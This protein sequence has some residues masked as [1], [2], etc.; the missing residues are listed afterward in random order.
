MSNPVLNDKNIYP[1]NK[2]LTQFLGNSK[3]AWDSFIDLL[4]VDYPLISTEWRYY[5]DGKRWLFKVTKKAKTVCW[6]S[7]W[8]KHFKVSFYFNNRAKDIIKNSLLDEEIKKRNR[9]S[10]RK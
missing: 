5:Y 4:K 1:D 8:E 2:V 9:G 7:V 10:K 3:N 6:V